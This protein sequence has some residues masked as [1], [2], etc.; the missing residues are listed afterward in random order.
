MTTKTDFHSIMELKEKYTPQE[1]GILSGNEVSLIKKVLELETRRVIELQNVR[2]MAVLLYSQWFEDLRSNGRSDE[3]MQLLD[4]RSAICCVI[5]QEK[6]T[7]GM[8]V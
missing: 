2:D 7:R 4:A 1:R 8:E 6:F 3:A 5:D